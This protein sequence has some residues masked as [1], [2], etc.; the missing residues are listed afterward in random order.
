MGGSKIPAV[1]QSI[2]S[3]LPSTVIYRLIILSMLGE[4]PIDPVWQGM[5]LLAGFT[6]VLCLLVVWRIRQMDR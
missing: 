4:V 3:W 5:L 2:L 6:L 1:L